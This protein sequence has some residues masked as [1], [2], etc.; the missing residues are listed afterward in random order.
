VT[1]LEQ[2]FYVGHGVKRLGWSF[3]VFYLVPFPLPRFRTTAGGRGFLTQYV[4]RLPGVQDLV[5]L[6]SFYPC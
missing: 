3:V 4:W 6:S 1:Y 5:V 2:S